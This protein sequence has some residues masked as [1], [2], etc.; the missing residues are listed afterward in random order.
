MLR[1]LGP[2]FIPPATK[3][4]GDEDDDGS[5]LGSDGQHIGMFDNPSVELPDEFDIDGSGGGGGGKGRRKKKKKKK[6]LPPSPIEPSWVVETRD[7]HVV[8][9]Q[10]KKETNKQ[11]YFVTHRLKNSVDNRPKA[12]I[13]HHHHHTL[14]YHSRP[15]PPKSP[16]AITTTTTPL[17]EKIRVAVSH[18]GLTGSLPQSA[19]R[20]SHLERLELPALRPWFDP[21][22]AHE[23]IP[24][25]LR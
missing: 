24:N 14:H 11:H 15:S 3:K 8:K 21:E 25:H 18:E 2:N 22:A 19:R 6:W 20:L 1:I 13:H 7:K 17:F 10:E 16:H 23:M 9:K 5:T 4:K 12:F